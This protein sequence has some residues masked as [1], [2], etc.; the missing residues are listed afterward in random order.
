[1]DHWDHRIHTRTTIHHRSRINYPR[2]LQSQTQNKP[3]ELELNNQFPTQQQNLKQHLESFIKDQANTI[4]ANKLHQP[5]RLEK[6]NEP[7]N[8]PAKRHTQT[9]LNHLLRKYKANKVKY[10][11]NQVKQKINQRLNSTFQYK[12]Q[13][14]KWINQEGS[15]SNKCPR[16]KI[17]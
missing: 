13:T 10:C 2:D 16:N 11:I 5:N 12:K 1:M 15:N 7:T 4:I 14:A 6:K 3:T 8:Q 9:K 17:T